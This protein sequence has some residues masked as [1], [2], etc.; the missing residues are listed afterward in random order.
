MGLS[1]S[2]HLAFQ[3][4]LITKPLTDLVR[5]GATLDARLIGYVAL[6]G[7]EAGRRELGFVIGARTLWRRGL[8]AATASAGLH[9]GFVAM[10]LTQ[11]WAEAL[12]ANAASVRILERLGM[13]E[14]GI[15][16][17]ATY[18]GQ[19][20]RHR[21]FTLDNAELEPERATGAATSTV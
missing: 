7:L 9:H 12:D 21:Q 19:P 11:I 20:S 10:G 18:L 4:G 2:E 5:L 3:T 15:G 1:L 6:Q 16:D 17:P 13:R 8:G 14:T